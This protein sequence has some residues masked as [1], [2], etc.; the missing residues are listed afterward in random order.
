MTTHDH[1]RERALAATGHTSGDQRPSGRRLEQD[2]PRSSTEGLRFE[3]R[4]IGL[5]QGAILTVI[6][7]VGDDD[8]AE[9]CTQLH[10][11]LDAAPTIAV[12]NLS[13][14]PRCAPTGVRV[15]CAAREHAHAGG[16][17]LY[18]VPPS[19]PD[20]RAWLSAASLA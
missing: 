18:L 8:V 4:S 16:I 17:D 11:V 6:G 15:L 3:L 9:L 5:G 7:A 20:A 19:D 1:E 13:G 14:V 10:T 12:V 2:D